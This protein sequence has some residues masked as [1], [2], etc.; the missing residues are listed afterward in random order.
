MKFEGFLH[1]T[2]RCAPEDLAAIERFYADVLGLQVGVRPDFSFPGAWLYNGDHPII[3]VA[4]RY[5]QG[6]VVKG[7]HSGSVDHLAWKTSGAVAFRKHLKALGLEF[8][9][10]NIAD[11]GYQVFLHDPVGTKL[12]FNF[13]DEFVA[14]AV[15]VGTELPLR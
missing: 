11:A 1:V 9:E 13:A 14:D 3:H 8:D 5:P 15:P 4:A 12:E 2:L 10:Q 7:Q 6:S